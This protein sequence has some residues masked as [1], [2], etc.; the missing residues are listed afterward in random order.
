MFGVL[1]AFFIMIF[2]KVY[3][4]ISNLF[5]TC[6]EKKFALQW[7]K[8]EK[9]CDSRLSFWFP[10][11]ASIGVKNSSREEP[12]RHL[13]T[14]A[15]PRDRSQKCKYSPQT[16]D[17]FPTNNYDKHREDSWNLRYWW[18]THLFNQNCNSIDHSCTI[19]SLF[20]KTNKHKSIQQSACSSLNKKT[21]YSALLLF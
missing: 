21:I 12:F 1:Y 8:T 6:W 15:T 16:L 17:R 2:F 20:L 13:G 11:C 4:K 19:S 3:L 7:N 10:M 9:Q 18:K 5:C 14:G